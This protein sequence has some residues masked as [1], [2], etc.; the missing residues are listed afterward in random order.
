M[1]VMH[2]DV[3]A[4]LALVVLNTCEAVLIGRFS[5]INSKAKGLLCIL[6]VERQ[7]LQLF[8]SYCAVCGRGGIREVLGNLTLRTGARQREVVITSIHNAVN[9][10]LGHC[11]AACTPSAIDHVRLIDVGELS[12]VLHVRVLVVAV[13][14]RSQQLAV[15]SWII[16]VITICNGYRYRTDIGIKRHS[17]FIGSLCTLIV[18]NLIYL[19][20]VCANLSEFHRAKCEVHRV[21]VSNCYCFRSWKHGL[22]IIVKCAQLEVEGLV[23]LHLTSLKGLGALDDIIAR[24]FS[25]CRLV[26]IGKGNLAWLEIWLSLDHDF[27]FLG[28]RILFFSNN[29]LDHV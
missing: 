14:Y 18:S 15:V 7:V 22:G 24:Q 20:G 5:L 8:H 23:F 19:E 16:T 4:I 28:I 17:I 2:C 3:Y 10:C 21:L 27:R 1:V 29:N 13:A 9:H 26:L 25:S 6:L 12:M 11:D